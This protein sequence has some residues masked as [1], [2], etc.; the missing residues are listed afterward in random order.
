MQ[1]NIR[2]L[3]E[4][5]SSR[6]EKEETNP[7][8]GKV[9]K[10][11]VARINSKP[12]SSQQNEKQNTSISA[13]R[14]SKVPNESLA[15]CFHLLQTELP[16]KDTKDVS[17]NTEECTDLFDNLPADSEEPIEFSGTRSLGCQTVDPRN[18]EE[19][20]V[21]GVIRYSSSRNLPFSMERHSGR[22]I[23]K[24]GVQRKVPAR[25]VGPETQKL[26]RPKN[27]QDVHE[28]QHVR[29]ETSYMKA[30][31]TPLKANETCPGTARDPFGPPPTYQRGVL[32]MYLQKRMEKMRREAED[33]KQRVPVLTCP[34]GSLTD[35]ERKEAITALERQQSNVLNELRMLPVKVDAR[36]FYSERTELMKKL[37]NI[38]ESLKYY[39]ELG[40]H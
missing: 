13:V 15:E 33:F 10:R 19:F 39:S 1:E 35:L 31:V 14:I 20:Y 3:Q 26:T 22:R 2:M 21:M 34:R 8:T 5:R 25:R 38:D 24:G 9:Y 37:K 23:S 29:N 16:L 27:K 6:R 18:L 12:Y 17:I 40:T 36:M 4:M 11:P 30:N 28:Y 7:M 32:P